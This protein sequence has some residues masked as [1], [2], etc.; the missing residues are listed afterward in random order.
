L[1]PAAARR[2]A[3]PFAPTA[4]PRAGSPIVEALFALTRELSPDLLAYSGLGG[5]RL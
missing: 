1:R 3:K 4:A 2:A 5:A